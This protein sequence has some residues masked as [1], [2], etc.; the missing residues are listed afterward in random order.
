[1]HERARNWKQSR[2]RHVLARWRRD[3][4]DGAEAEEAEG[5]PAR[6]D[7]VAGESSSKASARPSSGPDAKAPI[8]FYGD[9][10][11]IYLA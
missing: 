7:P 5:E 8:R 3:C 6:L 1:M 9:P 10:R 11:D 4:D 2:R